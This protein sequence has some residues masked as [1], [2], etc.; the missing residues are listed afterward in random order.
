MRADSLLSWF[1][2]SLTAA[3]LFRP[4]S[5]RVS[6]RVFWSTDFT[7]NFR[8]PPDR[9]PWACERADEA[10]PEGARGNG[11]EAEGVNMIR[12][13]HKANAEGQPGPCKLGARRSYCNPNVGR[14]PQAANDGRPTRPGRPA[15][16]RTP[17]FIARPKPKLDRPA[18]HPEG[19]GDGRFGVEPY[20]PS[21]N[22]F[23]PSSIA[24]RRAMEIWQRTTHH[25]AAL[26]R[27]D[28]SRA[29]VRQAS[30][31]LD[32]PQHRQ[33]KA[34]RERIESGQSAAFAQRDARAGIQP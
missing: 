1:S 31:A 6:W 16:H 2:N 22:S 14:D 4:R 15:S 20:P 27:A 33:H 32:D 3:Y 19:V 13:F 29:Y 17:F 28:A 21:R 8:E 25:T 10:H 9:W 12:A 24:H 18:A 11:P 23:Q 5:R 26:R 7:S 34:D 30:H